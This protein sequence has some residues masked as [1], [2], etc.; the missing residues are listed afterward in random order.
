MKKLILAFLV[1][2]SSANAQQIY[3]PKITPSGG[4]YSNLRNLSGTEIGTPSNPLTIDGTV[5]PTLPPNASTA[6]NQ[7]TEIT[8][9]QLLDNP[10]GSVSGGTAG[11]SSY[12]GGGVYSSSFPTLT[13]GQQLGLQL[14]VNGALRTDATITSTVGSYVDKG[15]FTYGTDK[16]NPTGGIYQDTSPG[17]TAGQ[18]GVS[19]MTPNR[20]LHVNLRD[21]SGTEF[22]TPTNPLIIAPANSLGSIKFGDVTTSAV[23]EVS[24]RRT[25]YTEQTTN[26]QRSI[27]SANAND[28]SAGTGARTLMITYFDQTGAG[29]FNETVTLNGTSCVATASSTIA[30]IERMEVLTVG[31]T[32]SNVGIISLRATNACGGATIGTIAAKSI[33]TFWA[34]HYVALGKVANITGISVNHSGTTVGSGGVFVLKHIEINSANDAEQQISDTVRLYGQ[35]STFSRN[36]ASPIKVTGPARVTLYVAPETSSSTVY[37]GAMDFY[38]Q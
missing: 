27:Q 22:A 25:A 2:F 4:V 18:V 20:G 14:T 23:T 15:S 31:S 19:R 37:R 7:A 26:G 34:H 10:I 36:Y 6:T 12:L 3:N 13:N 30:Y 29:P 1:I 11:T 17:L 21:S 5:A 33:Q 24:V 32:G 38:E 28:T 16:F 9:L 8:S 35:S